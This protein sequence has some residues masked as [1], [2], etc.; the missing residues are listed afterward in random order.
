ML[1]RV[2]MTRKKLDS[3]DLSF[4]YSLPSVRPSFLHPSGSNTVVRTSED[5][6]EDGI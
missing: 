3:I 1:D 2:W 4:L 6:K 5:E